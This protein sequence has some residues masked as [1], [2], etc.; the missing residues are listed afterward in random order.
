MPMPDQLNDYVAW[1]SRLYYFYAIRNKL[2]WMR[3]LNNVWQFGSEFNSINV[4]ADASSP[5]QVLAD[6]GCV[7]K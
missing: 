4:S 5:K 3:Y 2:K 1:K 6:D 7:I